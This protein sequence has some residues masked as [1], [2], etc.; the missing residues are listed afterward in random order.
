[1][2]EFVQRITRES[3]YEGRLLI[4]EFKRE[5]NRVIRRKLMK[6]KRP[7]RSIKQQYERA[8]NL[9]RYQR[10][11]RREKERLRGRREVK[12]QT[13]R[14]NIPANIGEVQR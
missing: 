7:S 14:I 10:E 13:P 2:E 1:M 4:E 11:S 5:M 6:T 12:A 9:N 8:T 3:G